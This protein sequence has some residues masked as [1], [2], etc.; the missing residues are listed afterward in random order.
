MTESEQIQTLVEHL[1]ILINMAVTWWASSIVFSASIFGA[2]WK[3]QKQV[4]AM[5]LR[6][7]LTSILFLFFLS[8]IIFGFVIIFDMYNMWSIVMQS[9]DPKLHALHPVFLCATIGLSIGTSTFMLILVSW[10]AI[11]K[12]INSLAAKEFP[13]NERSGDPSVTN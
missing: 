13:T 5:Q 9:Q 10:I 8:T 11:S 6:K 7:G 12:H 3:Y 1:G 4:A 2:V